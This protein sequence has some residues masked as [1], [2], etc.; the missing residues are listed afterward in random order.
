MEWSTF[1]QIILIGFLLLALGGSIAGVS[2]LAGDKDNLA[3]VQKNLGIIL[4][5]SLVV[6][7]LIF[8]FIFLYVRTHPDAFIPISLVSHFVTFELAIVAVAA[9]VLQKVV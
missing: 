9:S 3:N 4:G 6:N 5:S 2:F 7:I 1:I 8:I